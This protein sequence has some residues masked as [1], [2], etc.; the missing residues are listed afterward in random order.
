MST[1]RAQVVQIQQAGKEGFDD[2][3][4]GCYIP[5]DYDGPLLHDDV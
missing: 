4:E 3:P 1:S 5:Y 2:V